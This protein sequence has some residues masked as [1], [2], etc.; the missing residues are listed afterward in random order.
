MWIY[1]QARPHIGD[2]LKTAIFGAIDFPEALEF[3]LVCKKRK[4]MT[5]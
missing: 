2:V 1:A 3:V 4:S 5:T